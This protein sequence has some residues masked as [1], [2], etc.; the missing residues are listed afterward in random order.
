MSGLVLGVPQTFDYFE[1]MQDRITR[2]VTDNSNISSDRFKELCM[3]TEELV[4][5]I[6]TVLDGQSAVEEGLI[7]E[8]GSLSAAL[9]CLYAMIEKKTDSSQ[10]REKKKNSKKKA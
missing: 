5:D 3:N 9:H 4:M 2:F 6:G 8:L 1:R 10:P 7:D